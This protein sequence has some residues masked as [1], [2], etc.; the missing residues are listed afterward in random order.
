[1]A[2]ICRSLY[3]PAHRRNL[4]L[5]GIAGAI[6]A[7]RDRAAVRVRLINDAQQHRGPDHGVLAH[8][9]GLT[10]GNTRLAIQD[11]GPAGNQPFVSPNDRYHCVFNGEIYNHRELV[12]RHG[13]TVRINCD[14]EIVPA[15]WS[16]LGVASL[17]ELRGMFAIA[18]VDS[19]EERLYLARDPFGIK[20]LHWRILPDGL[21]FAS[22]IRPLIQAAGGAQVYPQAIARYL[23]LGAT[24]ADQAPFFEITT[25]PP[26]SVASFNRD[27]RSA[28]Q[29]IQPDGPLEA[30]VAHADLEKALTESVEFTWRP[31]C[32]VRC[33]CP[34]VLTPRQ[35]PQWADALAETCTVLRS[36]PKTVST[37][38]RRQQR[39][40]VIT[41]TSSSECPPWSRRTMF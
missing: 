16:K 8:V 39:P 40:R 10:L 5:C 31:M 13:L 12:R 41:G 26:N 23:H 27:C 15:L 29:P 4:T 7:S 9:S 21:V 37:R 14:G 6:D 11:P 17:A 36:R 2:E 33:C 30:A 3:L 1:M 28:I 34:R 25:L 20:P 24:A 19:L 18:V 35:L 32:Q 38:V 22:E